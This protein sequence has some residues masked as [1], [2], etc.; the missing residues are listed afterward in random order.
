[1]SQVIDPYEGRAFVLAIKYEFHFVYPFLIE[2]CV[3]FSSV[4]S[5]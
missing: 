4:E 5:E 2:I 1:M 3:F